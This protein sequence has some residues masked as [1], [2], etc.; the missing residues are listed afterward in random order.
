[1]R[2]VGRTELET[3]TAALTAVLSAATG[4]DSADVASPPETAETAVPV[5]GSGADLPVLF[6]DLVADLIAQLEIHG[7]GLNQLRLDGLHRTDEGLTAWGYA[8]GALGGGAPRAIMV[9]P[10]TR[11]D[12]TG[13]I[14]LQF[15][16]RRED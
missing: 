15:T 11:E 9:E 7:A 8:F 14:I 4:G 6:A 12:A 13:E 10:S 1:V 5:R 3:L 2:V 16:L